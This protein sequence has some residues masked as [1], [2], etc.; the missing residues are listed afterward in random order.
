MIAALPVRK[1]SDLLRAAFADGRY[2]EPDPSLIEEC[3]HEGFDS[4]PGTYATD[5]L[6]CTPAS[7]RACAEELIDENGG[8]RG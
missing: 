6:L 4:N 3:Y 7:I 1:R 5:L 8:K 2:H